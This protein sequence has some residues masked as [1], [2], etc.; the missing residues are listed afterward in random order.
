MLNIRRCCT[1]RESDKE[2]DRAKGRREIDLAA[3]FGDCTR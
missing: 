3:G 2:K 1:K